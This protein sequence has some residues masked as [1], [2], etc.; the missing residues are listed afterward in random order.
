M[1]GPVLTRGRLQALGMVLIGALVG[2]VI[3]SSWDRATNAPAPADAGAPGPA[4]SD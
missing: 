4:A 1:S 3:A 2:Y